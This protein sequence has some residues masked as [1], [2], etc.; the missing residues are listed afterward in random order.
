MT[1]RISS[2]H[3]FV[4][5]RQAPHRCLALRRLVA[6][7][8]MRRLAGIRCTQCTGS[9]MHSAMHT[10]EDA[11]LGLCMHLHRIPLLQ[12]P[13]FHLMSMVPHPSKGQ[14]DRSWVPRQA[15]CRAAST[16]A[17]HKVKHAFR[18]G[19]PESMR[20]D[21]LCK[22]PIVVHPIHEPSHFLCMWRALEV[23]DGLHDV[24]L[25]VWRRG[26]SRVGAAGVIQNLLSGEAHAAFSRL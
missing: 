1:N 21:Q 15:L 5:P 24:E 22:H 8:C 12:C 11:N 23:R 16:L 6:S 20:E 9:V 10:H 14:F 7:D 25:A 18:D 2:S 26:V 13:C 17:V 4:P 3:P 19:M